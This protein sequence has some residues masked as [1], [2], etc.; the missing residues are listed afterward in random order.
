M[1]V[2]DAPGARQTSFVQTVVLFA[3]FQALYAL[4]SSGNVFRAP[5]EFEV[6][7]QVEHLVDAGDLSVPQTLAITQPKVVGGRVV[8][9]ESMFF[10]EIGRDGRPYAP[11]GPLA[12]VLALPYHLLG[13]GVAAAAGV[14]RAPL[15]DGIAWLI[16]VGGVTMLATA[17]AGALAVAGFHRA[18]RA[19]GAR[20]R[21][22]FALALMLGGATALWPYSTSF[23]SEAFQAAAFIWAAAL[24]IQARDSAGLKPCAAGVAPERGMAHGSWPTAS[25]AMAAGL[26]LVAGLTKVTSLVFA[27]AFVVAAVAERRLAWRTRVNAAAVLLGGIAIAAAVHVA[28]NTYRFGRP[29]DFGYDWSET[30][31][32]LPARAFLASDIPRGLA[33]LL[34]SPG[35]SIVVWA[36]AVVISIAAFRRFWARDRAAALGVVTAAA[37]GALF[38]AAYL[39]PEGGYSHGPRN[40]VPILPLLLLPAASAPEA[41][42]ARLA[43]VATACAVAGAA[44]AILATSVSYL[45]DQSLGGDLSSGAR[46]VYYERIDPPPGRVWNRYRLD[47]IPFLGTIRS[48]GWFTAANLGQGPDYFPLHLLQARRQLQDGES[49]PLWLVWGWPAAWL[50]ALAAASANA[51]IPECDRDAS[52]R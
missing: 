27:P 11:Y 46:T 44:V 8:G 36:P 28:W 20:V 13:R 32:Q 12:A 17:T 31:P 51:I 15:P 34:L 1:S 7:F 6:Y 4:S 2:S 29:F 50:A 25:T 16:V 49:I 42:G 23:F 48:S 30:I 5:D 38:Y 14:P 37:I 21:W 45:E 19:I 41:L 40:L 47:Y 3:L 18:V 10:G 22:A 33:V 43:R 52:R 39:F 24:L 26:L 35:K 9:T